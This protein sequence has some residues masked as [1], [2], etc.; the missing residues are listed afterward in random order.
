MKIWQRHNTTRHNTIDLQKLTSLTSTY[1]KITKIPDKC[2]LSNRFLVDLWRVAN[3][4]IKQQQD[5]WCFRII[6][7]VPL[8]IV[9]TSTL[10]GSTLCR[11][12]RSSA[13]LTGLVKFSCPETN[14]ELDQI[15]EVRD[16]GER[17]KPIQTRRS[18]FKLQH[19]HSIFGCITYFSKCVC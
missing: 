12:M 2:K 16:H 17:K 7:V 10:T 9:L 15:S 4:L 6:L 3:H 5:I 11:A 14:H 8:M 1:H 13:G 19:Q 18:Q